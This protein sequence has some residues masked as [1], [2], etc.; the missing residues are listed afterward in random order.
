MTVVVTI[1][2]RHPSVWT[3]VAGNLSTLMSK[4]A[5][6]FA[7]LDFWCRLQWSRHGQVAPLYIPFTE[8]EP[9]EE[10]VQTFLQLQRIL[11]F[12]NRMSL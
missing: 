3:D 2:C 7:V 9:S 1:F 11:V 8:T 12:H 6:S 4:N 10:D 5:I